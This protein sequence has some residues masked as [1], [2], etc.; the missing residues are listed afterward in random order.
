VGPLADVTVVD[1]T[2]ALSGPYATLLLAGLGATVIKIEEPGPGDVARGNVPYAGRDGIT[3]LPTHEDDMSVPFLERCRGKLGITLNLKHDTG[4][5]VLADLIRRSDIVVENFSAGTAERLGI[6]YDWARSI[7]RRVVYTSISGFGSSATED[8]KAYDLITQALSGLTLASGTVDEPP[9]RVGLPL[10]DAIAPLFAVIGTVAALHSAQ[11]TGEGQHVDVSMLG[12]LTSMVAIEPWQAYEAVEMQPRTGNFLNRLA[13]FGLFEAQDG[14]VAICAANDRFFERLP[15]ALDMPWLLTDP[16]FARRAERASNA[17]AIHAVL[18]AWVRTR[19]CRDVVE[20][21]AGF[22]V[23]AAPV[24][25]PVEAICDSR[26]RERGE[27]VPLEHPVYGTVADLVGS[28]VPIVLSRDASRVQG[29]APLLGQHNSH[30][31][32]DLLGYSTERVAAMA[33]EGVI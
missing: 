28:G 18:A 8:G 27:T 16:R 20:H 1:L 29:A 21:L 25:T 5:E 14:Y 7:N 30:V 24:R 31:Y 11:R 32:G 33:A 23:P 3:R 15:T 10:G 2:R 17:D 6:G 19:T 12:A 22:D 26:V 4:R 9:V 13:P